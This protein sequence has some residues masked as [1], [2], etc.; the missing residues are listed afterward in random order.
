MSGVSPI[1]SGIA[2]AGRRVL[3]CAA[4]GLVAFGAAILV[5]PWQVAVLLGWDA[6]GMAFVIWV[7]LLV[8]GKDGA[9]TEALATREDSSRAAADVVLISAGLANLIGVGAALLKAAGEKGGVHVAISAL[10]GLTVV[11]SWACVHTVFTLRYAHLY[12]SG[13]GGMDFH[14]DGRPD[15]GDFAYVALTL[16]MTYQVSDTD[17]T[18]K[19]IRVAALRHAVVSY[20]FGTVI[21][22]I[23]INVVAGLLS[24]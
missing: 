2:S 9:A 11:I 6:T 23:T 20:V 16:G 14:D 7:F 8:R 1:A 5:A 13:N 18:S 4:L 24:K 15:Y 10:A 22:A 21:I 12:Y 3:T 19:P 17:L